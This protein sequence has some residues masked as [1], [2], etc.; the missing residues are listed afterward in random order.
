MRVAAI[1]P[2]VLAPNGPRT[3]WVGCDVGRKTA[4]PDGATHITDK[5]KADP[6]RMGAGE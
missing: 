4:Q 6:I 1:G 5:K 3:T 2:F